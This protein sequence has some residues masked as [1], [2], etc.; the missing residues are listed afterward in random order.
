MK[1]PVILGERVATCFNY[2]LEHKE[3][4]KKCCVYGTGPKG[5]EISNSTKKKKGKLWH[6]NLPPCNPV[7]HC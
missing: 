3:G 1:E 7:E 6:H 5:E 4:I 2:L